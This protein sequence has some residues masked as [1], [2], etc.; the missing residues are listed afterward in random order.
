V[1]THRAPEDAAKRAISI[2]IYGTDI[3][4]IGSSARRYYD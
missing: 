1:V 3:T 2:H 4:R